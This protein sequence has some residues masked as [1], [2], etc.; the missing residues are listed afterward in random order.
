TMGRRRLCFAAG[1]AL[2]VAGSAAYIARPWLQTNV[3]FLDEHRGVF[4]LGWALIVSGVSLVAYSRTR[5]EDSDDADLP[6]V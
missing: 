2:V 3:A 6:S 4:L 1:I 5:S